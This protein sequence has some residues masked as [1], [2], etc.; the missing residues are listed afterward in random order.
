MKRFYS[1]EITQEYLNDLLAKAKAAVQKNA[2]T[3]KTNN[4]NKTSNKPRFVKN[5]DNRTR[6]LAT[7]TNNQNG[8][9]NRYKNRY[10][11]RYNN[12]NNKLYQVKKVHANTDTTSRTSA[13]NP[14]TNGVD[15]IDILDEPTSLDH[16]KQLKGPLETNRPKKD[17]KQHSNNNRTN[18]ITTTYSKNYNSTKDNNYSYLNKRSVEQRKVINTPVSLKETKFEIDNPQ[19]KPLLKYSKGLT[20]NTNARL[21]N[22][23]I[24]TLKQNNFPLYTEPHVVEP[25]FAKEPPTRFL[26]G[27]SIGKLNLQKEPLL[28]NL[29]IKQDPNKFD[30]MIRGNY[31][32]N[33][34]PENESDNWLLM[35]IQNCQ[36]LTLDQ[37]N[38]LYN[39]CKDAIK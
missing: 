8:N 19:I 35:N 22:Y 3:R 13:I 23:A 39:F 10:N 34:L 32:M 29:N 16:S 38:Y 21:I 5:W 1:T 36:G 14:L 33:V 9:I 28:K 20:F 12:T 25:G 31:K 4:L 30:S 7:N 17:A 11:N 6:N 2:S 26:L 24:T 27:K 15:M 37:R 18:K